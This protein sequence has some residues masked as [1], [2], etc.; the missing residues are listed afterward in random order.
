MDIKYTYLFRAVGNKEASSYFVPYK[1]QPVKISY[2]LGKLGLTCP[3]LHRFQIGVVK[4]SEGFKQTTWLPTIYK[5]CDN[6][7]DAH[8]LQKN[9]IA[10][11]KS[12]NLISCAL[13]PPLKVIKQIMEIN[14][15]LR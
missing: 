9:E 15:I 2:M 14:S 5:V 6:V 1:M 10:L 4:E 13:T 8:K 12:F 11:D 3:S 7:S